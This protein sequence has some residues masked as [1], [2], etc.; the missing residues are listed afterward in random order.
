M[1]VRG[2]SLSDAKIRRYPWSQRRAI[3]E[4][5]ARIFARPGEPTQGSTVLTSRQRLGRFAP[6][7]LRLPFASLGP[8]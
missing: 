4:R 5:T 3:R 1:W 6:D 8:S 7:P 2:S